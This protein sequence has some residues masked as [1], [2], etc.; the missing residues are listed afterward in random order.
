MCDTVVVTGEATADGATLF[1]KNTDREPNEAHEVV[2]VPR[3]RHEPGSRVRCTYVEIPQV[4]QTWAVLLAKPYWIWGAEMGANE[5]GLAIGNEAV[6]TRVAHEKT[7]GLIGMDLLRLAL[8]RARTAEEGVGVITRLLE[9]F[10]QGGNC[11]PTHTFLYHNSFLLADPAEAWVLETAGRQWAAR[12][13]RGVWTLS[14]GLTL[15]REW[16][17]ASADLVRFA[18]DRRWCKGRDDFDFARCYSDPLVTRLAQAQGRQACTLGF[19]R[20]V[21]GQATVQHVAA[22]LRDHGP[23]APGTPEGWSPVPGLM[24]RQTCQHAGWGPIRAD[25]ATGSMLSRLD[26][27]GSVHFV[28]RTSGPCTSIYRPAWVE[29][30]LPDAGPAPTE[31]FDE[32][33]LFWRHEVLHRATLR[34]YG[35]LHPLYA[36]ER[37]AL[38]SSIFTAALAGPADRAA[39]AA[40]C[41]ARADRA[42]DDWRERVLAAGA[43]DVRGALYR[44]AWEGWNRKAGLRLEAPARV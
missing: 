31:R 24:V 14:N 29:A 11:S 2:R 30:E 19:L 15:G 7:P 10:G 25:Q 38:E 37:D 16:D 26:P 35:R 6:F 3:A 40:E 42:E 41:H 39:F 20:R 23:A 17:L 13:V 27:A 32:R 8:E 36:G 9:E 4:E 43:P 44:M 33:T 34:N 28:T 5:H 21:Q 1:G 12:R 22:A 18:V